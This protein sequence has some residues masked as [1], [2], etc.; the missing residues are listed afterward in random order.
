MP[1]RIEIDPL[2]LGSGTATAIAKRLGISVDTVLARQRDAG[3]PIRPQGV[4]DYSTQILADVPGW[5]NADPVIATR[6]RW[7]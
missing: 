6:S 4:R 1:R 3:I 2:L 7:A 5:M